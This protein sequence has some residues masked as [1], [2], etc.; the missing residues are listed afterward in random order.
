MHLGRVFRRARYLSQGERLSEAGDFD[1]ALVVYDE[2][3]SALPNDGHFLLH[4]ALAQANAGQP[5]EAKSTLHEA[6]ELCP[7]QSVYPLFLGQ[8]HYDLGE[9][10]EALDAFQLASRLDPSNDLIKAYLGLTAMTLGQVDEG[11]AALVERV[12]AANAGCQGRVLLCCEAY[13][14]RHSGAS[15]PLEQLV[16][17]KEGEARSRGLL[18]P[19][20]DAMERGLIRAWHGAARPLTALRYLSNAAA[21]RART[22]FLR[23]LCATIWRSTRLP[24]WPSLSL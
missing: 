1:Q 16:S 5:G 14:A 6:M 22:L 3:L 11:Y 9:T 19:I 15:Q 23:G 4:K 2:G 13:L 20:A 12:R 8:V 17:K 10:E 21:R 18:G 24:G 7:R